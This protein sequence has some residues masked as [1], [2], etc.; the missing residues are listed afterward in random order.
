MYSHET[1]LSLVTVRRIA[2]I[3]CAAYRARYVWF[4]RFVAWNTSHMAFRVLCINSSTSF[5][6]SP[7]VEIGGSVVTRTRPLICIIF[8]FYIV[9]LLWFLTVR[10]IPELFWIHSQ[11]SGKYS[12][13]F[14]LFQNNR[15]T[16]NAVFNV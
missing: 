10:N 14:Q 12:R 11:Y 3:Q 9:I 7:S 6:P 5:V 1:R 4:S 8:L 15:K 16:F 2:I 13:V